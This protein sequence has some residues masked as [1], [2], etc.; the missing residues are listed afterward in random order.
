MSY[1]AKNGRRFF[2]NGEQADT[3]REL[4]PRL[5]YSHTNTR[6][7]YR[8][9]P[10]ADGW[11]MT[12]VPTGPRHVESLDEAAEIMDRIEADEPG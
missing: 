11:T 8:L 4:P 1:V 5:G 2:W 10:G 3:G 7:S 6:G 12:P 9:K